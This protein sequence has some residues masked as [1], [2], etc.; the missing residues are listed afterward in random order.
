MTWFCGLGWLV[1]KV[2]LLNGNQS[3]TAFCPRLRHSCSHSWR[4]N[5]LRKFSQ[6]E[7]R[8]RILQVCWWSGLGCG[9]LSD[10]PQRIRNLMWWRVW[11]LLG[12]VLKDG[13]LSGYLICI[14]ELCWFENNFKCIVKVN[15][16][17]FLRLQ[18]L[19][20][21]L[22]ILMNNKQLNHFS[23]SSHLNWITFHT[24]TITTIVLSHVLTTQ[25]REGKLFLNTL[26]YGLLAHGKLKVRKRSQCSIK[27][28]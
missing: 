12:E 23:C 10:V 6:G 5:S 24:R 13:F 17:K 28:D 2:D 15:Y 9:N 22:K 14:V 1:L 21:K 18:Y 3:G 7:E 8:G 19:N 20:A 4:A 26:P 25:W 16:L 27:L 11:D